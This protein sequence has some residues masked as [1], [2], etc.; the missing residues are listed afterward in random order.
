MLNEPLFMESA[1]ALAAKTL[2]EAGSGNQ[3]RLAFAFRRCLGRDP[4]ADEA[5]EM[6]SFLD[7]QEGRLRD[8][9]LSAPDLAGLHGKDTKEILALVPKGS[10]PVDLA[11]WTAVSRVLLNLDETITKE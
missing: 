11:A 6:L 2:R 4:S 7:K 5:A 8:G 3:Q 10:T 1:Q 9:W